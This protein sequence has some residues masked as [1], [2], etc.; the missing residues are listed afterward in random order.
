MIG[1]EIVSIDT[2]VEQHLEGLDS[3][4]DTYSESAA[5]SLRTHIL[6]AFQDN[7]DARESGGVNRLMLE[8]LRAYN[9]QYDPE[10]LSKI[11]EEGGSEIYMNLTSTKV[12][13]LTS[14]IKDILLASKEDSFSIE[15]TPVVDLPGEVSEQIKEAVSRDFQELMQKEQPQGKPQQITETLREIN[16]RKRDLHDAIVEEQNKEARYAF[17]QIELKLKDSL[18]EG[19]WDKALSE[20]IDDFS[21]FPTAF[22]KGPIVTKKKKLK[23]V[24]GVAEVVEDYAFVF[25]RVS[26][27][28]VYPAP[29][30]TCVSDGNFIE[31]LRLSRKELASFLRFPEAYKV[32]AVRR[33]L[34]NEEG[35]GYP[36]GLD[37]NVE[38]E[39]AR[40]ELR[41]D[42]FRANKNVFHGLHFHG[43][44]PCKLL[45]EW[46]LTEGIIHLEDEDEVDIEAILVGTEIIKCKLNEDPL[47]RRMYYS[48]S[49]QKRPDSIWGSAPPFLMKDIQRMCNACARALSNNMGLSSGPIMELNIERLADG[50]DIQELRPRDIVQTTS[51]PTGASGKAVSF[52]AIPSIAQE[53]LAVYKEFELRADDVT[54][55]P[56]YAYGN[57]RT[58]QAAATASGLSM[59]LESANKGIKD[60]IRHID[61]GVI[62]PL[63]ES[64]F[65]YIMLNEELEF[66]GDINVIAKGSATLT[67]AAA[68]QMRR[69]E[70]LQI[71]ANPTDLEIIGI[72]G[73]AKMLRQASEDLG[74]DE[75]LV[76]N[77]QELKAASEKKAQAQQQP[78]EAAQI[79]QLQSETNREIAREKNEIAAADLQRRK[80]KDAND[81]RIKA[82][83]LQLKEQ[84]DVSKVTAKLQESRERN[85]SEEFRTEQAIALSLSTG[86]KANNV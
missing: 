27:L 64:Q 28:D 47:G 48:A 85:E 14:W 44:A 40:E 29:E 63:V 5:S 58:G 68:R 66:S 83:E 53:L 42:T 10:I 69:N 12:R 46:G 15:P 80:E 32:E 37:T 30:A 77:R 54:M 17:Q 71:T 57:E 51:D 76:P 59:L 35:K 74:F 31:H 65:Y 25:K 36:S 11:R 16:E 18:K 55:I 79:T 9:G 86:D 39:K 67:I 45:R 20:F 62:I 78:S 7:K 8:A 61:E 6:Q 21:I 84:A 33:V 13:A 73:R 3:L 60:A 4:E 19:K 1:V 75:N 23:W 49:Y 52:F 34:E 24:E 22:L 41:E 50:Q 38:D 26:P 81:A 43:T 2:L 72:Q 56:R 82:V 70:F